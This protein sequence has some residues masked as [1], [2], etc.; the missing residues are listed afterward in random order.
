MKTVNSQVL[1]PKKQILGL[2]ASALEPLRGPK[3]TRKL[4]LKSPYHSTWKIEVHRYGRLPIQ[5]LRYTLVTFPI[6]SFNLV[7][8]EKTHLE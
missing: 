2:S 7:Q 5:V 4:S 1:M 8:N 3:Q 6:I